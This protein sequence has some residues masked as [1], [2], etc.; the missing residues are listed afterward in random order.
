VDQPLD[1]LPLIETYLGVQIGLI[2]QGETAADK[3][4]LSNAKTAEKTNH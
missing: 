1:L 2:S 3:Q 4:F